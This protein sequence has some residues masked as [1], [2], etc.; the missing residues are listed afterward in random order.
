MK[1]AW[2][3]VAAGTG[4]VVFAAAA[5]I[6]QPTVK[7]VKY[8]VSCPTCVVE[9]TPVVTIGGPNDTVSLAPN[10][11][12]DRDSQG[13]FFA[14]SDDTRVLVYDARGRLLKTLG[15]RGDG[16][17]EFNA[18]GPLKIKD[19]VVGR[20]D[21]V[22]VFHEPKVTVYSPQLVYVRTITMPVAQ[23]SFYPLA[24]GTW[25][26]SGAS[27]TPANVG[28]S[29]FIVNPDGTIRR[30]LGPEQTL[31]PGRRLFIPTRFKAAPDRR[32]LW[33][34]TDYNRY[35]FSQWSIDNRLLASLEIHDAPFLPE[36]KRVTRRD[37]AGRTYQSLLGGNVSVTGLD[38][39]GQIWIWG[40][41]PQAK[42]TEG[43]L[44]VI[45]P[46]TGGIRVSQRTT[47]PVWLLRS[48]AMAYTPTT[49]DD[50]FMTFVVSRYRIV[51][52]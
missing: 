50:G 40:R 6:A 24:D 33:I 30:S 10:S 44:E 17:G 41:A 37:G 35:R 13:R 1:K 36:P 51:R 48:G 45:D 4:V 21:S 28:R 14:I 29:I 23:S 22:F 20:G 43:V 25:L 39:L 8:R 2:N 34:S 9:L 5:A 27:R 19:V 46:V 26:V 31:A 12:L 32:S 38:T 15:R 18:R 11:F 16:P 3:A 49:D 42:L 7:R 47:T 52:R